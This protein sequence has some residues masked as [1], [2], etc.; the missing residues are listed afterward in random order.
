MGKWMSHDAKKWDTLYL[1]YVLEFL[2]NADV[3]KTENFRSVIL[4]KFSK[5][6]EKV[7]RF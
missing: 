7:K 6:T 1:E 5:V 4:M 3:K 2:L